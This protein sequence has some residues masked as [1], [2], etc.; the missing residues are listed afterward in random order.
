MEEPRETTSSANGTGEVTL[1]YEM[2]D[3]KFPIEDG[4]ITAAAIDDIYCLSFAMPNCTLHLGY[5]S[6][7][8][9]YA[10]EAEGV[11]MHYLHEDPAGTFCGLEGGGTYWVYVSQDAEE[12]AKDRE[13]MK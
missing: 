8:D 9:H 10:S 12:E 4:S 5:L 11:G 2:Y 7:S 6:P 13:R 3:E 1:K